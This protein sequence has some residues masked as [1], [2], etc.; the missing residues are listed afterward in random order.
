[1][2]QTKAL[3]MTTDGDICICRVGQWVVMGDCCCWRSLSPAS[4]A[5]APAPSGHSGGP[6]TEEAECRA[7]RRGGRC[8]TISDTL[9]P[10]LQT[11]ACITKHLTASGVHCH[12]SYCQWRVLTC[13]LLQ[14]ACIT[15]HLTNQW[16]ALPCI[17]Y[18]SGVPYRS[19]YTQWRALP[20]MTWIW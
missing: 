1:M 13:I 10:L 6:E 2:P 18:H 11:V 16:R 15:V 8:N 19:S 3:L 5:P 9:D 7:W 12:A 17:L 14:V 4:P 20:C